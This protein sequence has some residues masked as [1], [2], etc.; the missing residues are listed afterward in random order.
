MKHSII[1]LV[2]SLTASMW[3]WQTTGVVRSASAG[4]R[5][6]V[7]IA[8]TVDGTRQPSYIILPD[9]FDLNGSRVPLLV[10]LHS[11]SRDLEYRSWKLERLAEQR[12]WIYLYPN[13]RGPN[14]HPDACGSHKAQQD[15]LDAV[16]WAKEKYPVDADRVYIVG[17]SGGGHMTMLMVGRHPN[18]WTAASA[19]VGISDLVAW[20]KLHAKDKYG[21]MMRLACGGAP[22]DG[23]EV[24]REYRQRSPL[25]HLKGAVDV[26]LDLNTGIHDGHTGSVPVRH[27]LDAFNVIARAGG[28]DVIDE[29]EIQQLSRPDGRLDR[30]RETDLVTDEAYGRRIHLRR[31]A[32]PVRVTVFEGGHEILHDVAV[33][34]LEKKS[35]ST[36]NKLK[37]KSRTNHEDHEGH[38]KR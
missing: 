25:T 23:P 17:A 37:S 13:F 28:H 10:S 3:A 24:E 8:S 27:T 32:G 33:A 14:E 7:W 12:G 4:E 5:T 29:Q 2:V 15:I 6:K 26:P 34:W 20:H 36:R 1:H 16:A 30:P 19:W 31:F 9:G 11:W 35:R 21:R 18:V 38:E 22:E